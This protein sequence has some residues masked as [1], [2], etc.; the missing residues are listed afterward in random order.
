MIARE[1]LKILSHGL[2][3]SYVQTIGARALLRDGMQSGALADQGE[4]QLTQLSDDLDKAV[5]LLGEIARKL[6]DMT[7]AG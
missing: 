5:G 1:F 3:T 2:E 4:K 7:P 6:A